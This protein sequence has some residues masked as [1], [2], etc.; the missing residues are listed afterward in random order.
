[1]A[2][3]KSIRIASLKFKLTASF[4]DEAASTIIKSA[5]PPKRFASVKE[6]VPTILEGQQI[7]VHLT[8]VKAHNRPAKVVE[9]NWV[10]LL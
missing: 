1:M 3:A 4:E 7:E 8:A 5:L 9:I 2:N 10:W 6:P